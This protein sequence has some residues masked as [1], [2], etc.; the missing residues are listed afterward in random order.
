[1]VGPQMRSSVWQHAASAGAGSTGLSAIVGGI[2]PCEWL[3]L[4]VDS[5]N[6]TVKSPTCIGGGAR[7]VYFGCL[8]DA[9]AIGPATITES[10]VRNPK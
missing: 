2:M 10:G 3:E 9:C 5:A 8:A 4:V 1:M 7:F 6:V